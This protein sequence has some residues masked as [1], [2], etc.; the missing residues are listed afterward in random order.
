MNTNAA[1]E[2]FD[3]VWRL[4]EIKYPPR[5]QKLFKIVTQNRNGPCSLIA[6]VNV[7]I[8]RQ[9]IR[10]LPDDRHYVSYEYLASLVAD[11]LVNS[12]HALSETDLNGA[13]A[14]LPST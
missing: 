9:S 5:S 7:L 1:Q 14:V 3:A 2:S 11:Y 12:H 8:L 4:K 10:I 6:L 13:L